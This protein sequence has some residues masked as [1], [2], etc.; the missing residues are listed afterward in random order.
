MDPRNEFTLSWWDYLL[1]ILTLGSSALI[2]IYYS[3]SKKK[4]KT[5]D[6]Y[7]FGSMNMPWL[8]ILLSNVSST[9]KN[10]SINLLDVAAH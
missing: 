4:P 9:L 5:L 3:F 2:G 7:M 1:L 8:P 10:V 6:E